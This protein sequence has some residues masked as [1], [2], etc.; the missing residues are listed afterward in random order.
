MTPAEKYE[1]DRENVQPIRK[2]WV[3]AWDDI[4]SIREPKH[5]DRAVAHALML[6]AGNPQDNKPGITKFIL[7]KA[8]EQG[9]AGIVLLWMMQNNWV[10]P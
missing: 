7:W 6:N 8:I 5:I 9:R 1:T 3:I 4:V 10:G 2:D